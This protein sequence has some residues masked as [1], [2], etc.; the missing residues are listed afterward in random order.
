MNEACNAEL[1]FLAPL[2]GVLG[3]CQKVK[4][5][6]I[7]ITKLFSKILIPNCV[8]TNERYKTY[9]IGF[10]YCCLGL[11]PGVGLWGAGVPRGSKNSNKVMWLIKSTGM[12]SRT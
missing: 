7:S 2:P 9:Q 3:M 8:L 12:T 10:S 5:H 6:L 11:A 1:F 4:Y